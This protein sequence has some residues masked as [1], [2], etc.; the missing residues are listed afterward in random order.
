LLVIMLTVILCRNVMLW[1]LQWDSSHCCSIGS[2][3]EH[4]LYQL[5]TD[6]LKIA[7][8]GTAEVY[9]VEMHY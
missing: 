9:K 6:A 1:M 2:V 3:Q 4:E 7:V 8:S 5:W